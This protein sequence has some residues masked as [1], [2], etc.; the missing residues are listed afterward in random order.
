MCCIFKLF[1]ITKHTFWN[2][3]LQTVSPS[4]LFSESQNYGDAP[5]S[6]EPPLTTALNA[7]FLKLI[8]T[9]IGMMRDTFIPLSFLD[10]IF[11]AQFL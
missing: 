9:L 2:C 10:Q 11:S 6:S 7:V 4:V 8:L 1:R 3:P 5:A